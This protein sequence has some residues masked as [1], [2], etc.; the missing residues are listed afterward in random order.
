[1][2]INRVQ[3]DGTV[4]APDRSIVN[5][6]SGTGVAITLTDDA[7]AAASKATFAT[8]G[9]LVWQTYVDFSNSGS[10]YKFTPGVAGRIRSIQF[11]VTTPVTT[12]VTSCTVRPKIAG[13]VTT[14]GTLSLTQSNCSTSGNEVDGTA[15]TGNNVFTAAQQLSVDLSSNT[16]TEGTG[17]ISV[18]FG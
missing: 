12:P 10:S 14:G 11:Q 18:T 3:V 9:P 6:A 13:S 17:I 7:T 15:I 5:F 4:A 1:M 16:L 8:N 2:P